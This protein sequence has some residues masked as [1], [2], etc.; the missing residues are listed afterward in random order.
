MPLKLKSPIVVAAVIGVVVVGV[1]LAAWWV[2]SDSHE[3]LLDQLPPA[4][5]NAISAE[6]D[7]AGI[8]YHIDREKSGITVASK[9]MQSARIAAMSSGSTL[10]ESA[11]LELF[12][13]SDFGMTDFTQKINYQR[14]M[15]GEIA[16]TVSALADV[17]FARVHLV[18]PEHGLFQSEKQKPKASITLFLKDGAN[19]SSQQVQSIQRIAM[20]AIPDLQ[21]QDVTV[22]NQQGMTLSTAADD[23]VAAPAR[24]EQKKAIENYLVGKV[25]NVLE[26]AVG[27]N[28][29]AVSVDVGLDMTQKTKTTEK[30]LDA[31]PDAGIKRLKATTSH[32]KSETGGDDSS[33]EVEYALGHES[34][35]IV[36][37]VGEVK[38]IQVGVIVDSDVAGVDIN[39]LRELI[40]ATAGVDT[41]RGDKVSVIQNNIAIQHAMKELVNTPTAETLRANN[42]DRSAIQQ[43]LFIALGVLIGSVVSWFFRGTRKQA[44]SSDEVNQLRLELQRWIDSDVQELRQP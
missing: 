26:K 42:P 29:F 9:D 30:I 34:E 35:Q 5:L 6:L 15:E 39:R 16:R 36:S 33:K 22:V 11:G 14:A 19:L 4:Q 17:K 27:Q 1:L 8:A 2:L 25:R 44:P 24:L 12:D 10:R 31:G 7:R 41:T 43:W 3:V 13:K 28:R 23:T 40:A 32:N 20:S 38:Q 21:A 37:G 18:L